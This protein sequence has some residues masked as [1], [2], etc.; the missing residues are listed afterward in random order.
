MK[1][2]PKG[3][4]D[5]F[6]KEDIP[7][8]VMGKLRTAYQSSGRGLPQACPD[9][10]RVMAYALGELTSEEKI[11]VY[12]HLSGCKECIDLVL[13]TR[14]AWAEAQEQKLED[15]EERLAAREKP[16]L[17]KFVGK[18]REWLVRL[19]SLPKLVPAAV[20][21]SLV[22]TI[23]SISVYRQMTAPI[24]IQLDLIAK[25][26]DGLLTRGPSEEK[27]I[28]VPK[29]GVLQSGDRFQIA[30]KTSKDAYVYVFFQDSTG[31]ITKLFSGNV[32]G[33]KNIRLPGEHD[34]FK[35]R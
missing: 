5:L 28:L 12:I 30:F 21:A 13:D 29:G 22:V 17:A 33:N 7:E 16:A 25:T 4:L 14:S 34:W 9:P 10:E 24:G 23:L 32:L 27:E 11:Q 8:E 3:D 31:K 15:R 19:F 1:D 35:L 6:L 26:S 20:A 18:A 2:K